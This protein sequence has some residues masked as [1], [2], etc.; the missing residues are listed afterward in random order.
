MVIIIF[1]TGSI[2][3]IIQRGPGGTTNSDVAL[4]KKKLN[5]YNN[6]NES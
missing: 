5:G 3:F 4:R 6:V 2:F 1:I